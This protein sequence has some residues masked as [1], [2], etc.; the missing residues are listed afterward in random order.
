MGLEDRFL[1]E[2]NLDKPIIQF[3]KSDINILDDLFKNFFSLSNSILNI[4]LDSQLNQFSWAGRYIYERRPDENP[5]VIIEK[6]KHNRIGEI[7]YQSGARNDLLIFDTDQDYFELVGTLINEIIKVMNLLSF[8]EISSNFDLNKPGGIGLLE[9]KKT[10]RPYLSKVVKFERFEKA[11]E[12][13]KIY[14]E[15]DG[16]TWKEVVKRVKWSWGITL[17]ARI[18]SLR[19]TRKELEHLQSNAS[20]Q[21][22]NEFDVWREE[23]KGKIT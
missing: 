13:I 3:N 20:N 11:L 10:G 6:E 23:Q 17:N 8:G 9:I 19:D 7:I 12:A 21:I 5:W 1:R 22:L 4:Y 18:K 15:V 14:E 2:D 16:I